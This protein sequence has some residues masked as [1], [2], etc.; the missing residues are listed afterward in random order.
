MSRE[1]LIGYILRYSA[2]ESR[3]ALELMS[4]ESLLLIKN[5]IETELRQQWYN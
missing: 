4:T 2:R 5:C 1:E 3:E